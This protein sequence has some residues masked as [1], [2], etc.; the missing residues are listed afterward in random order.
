MNSSSTFENKPV[1]EKHCSSEKQEKPKE[2]K[3]PSPVSLELVKNIAAFGPGGKFFQPTI[4]GGGLY[5]KQDETWWSE[6]RFKNLFDS[7]MKAFRQARNR[8]QWLTTEAN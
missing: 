3:G 2:D 1:G 5:E 8:C 4:Q 6:S 7:K